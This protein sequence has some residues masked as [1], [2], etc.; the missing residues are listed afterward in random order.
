MVH[1]DRYKLGD[2]V[3]FEVPVEMR[4]YAYGR[5][6]MREG[7]LMLKEIGA[8]SGEAYSVC[9][10]GFHIGHHYIGPVY[11]KDSAGRD[12]PCLRGKFT[13]REGCFL[14]VSRQYPNSFDGRY[15][16]DIPLS[17][18]HFKAIPVFVEWWS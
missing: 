16:G 2:I 3:A 5:K 12:M 7:D 18:I 4:P 14:P 17:S 11:Q 15:F 13:V 8:F 10:T 9:E 1:T 6:W